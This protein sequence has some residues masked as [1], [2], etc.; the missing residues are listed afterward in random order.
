MSV[1]TRSYFLQLFPEFSSV[2]VPKVNAYLAIAGNR[3]DSNAWGDCADYAQALILAH[4]LSASGSGQSDGATGGPVTSESVGDL[5][6][7]YG[8]MQSESEAD[9]PYTMT[10][11]GR[12]YLALRRECIIPGT[13]TDF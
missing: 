6:R 7:Q 1:I 12:E 13:L 11:Y 4:M 3:V 9:K 2:A 8:T 10:K 5:S